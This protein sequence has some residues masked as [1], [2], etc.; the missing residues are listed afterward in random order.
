MIP[1]RLEY[2]SLSASNNDMLLRHKNITRIE[3]TI[4]TTNV[5]NPM[6]TFVDT[7]SVNAITNDIA[8]NI[9]STGSSSSDWM[10]IGAVVDLSTNNFNM[11]ANI[12]NNDGIAI[13]M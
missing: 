2:K 7:P 10:K 8:R 6:L 13:S 11:K 9:M 1:I 3:E 12:S 5:N 4:Y